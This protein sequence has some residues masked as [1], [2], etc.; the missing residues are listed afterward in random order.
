[1]HLFEMVLVAFVDSKILRVVRDETHIWLSNGDGF[2]LNL[3]TGQIERVDKD[4]VTE[5]PSQ[6]I[7][8][9]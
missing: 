2:P 3:L 8:F 9:E 4:R 5:T 1:M 7:H 6:S